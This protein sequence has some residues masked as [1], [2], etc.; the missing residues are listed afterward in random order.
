MKINNYWTK[1]PTRREV[2][3]KTQIPNSGNFKFDYKGNVIFNLSL[4]Y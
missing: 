4:P 3:T 2:I 1:D